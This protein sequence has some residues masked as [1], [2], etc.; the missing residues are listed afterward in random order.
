[1]GSLLVLLVAGCPLVLG[2]SLRQS[3]VGRAFDAIDP[4]AAALNTLMPW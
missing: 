3:A 4:F 2:P 1:M